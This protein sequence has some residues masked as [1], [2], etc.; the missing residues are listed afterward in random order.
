MNLTTIKIDNCNFP[1][2]YLYDIQNFVWADFDNV[3]INKIPSDIISS[4]VKIG[5]MPV[6]S[7]I[8]GKVKKIKLKPE[9]G[10]I[11]K[12]KS[13]GTLESLNYFGVI[14]SPISGEIVEINKDLISD[15]EKI[16]DSPFEFGW[17]A[18]IKPSDSNIESLQS[19]DQCKSEISHLIKK[20][21][22]KCFK[23][24]PDFEMYELGTECSATLAK[25][26]EFMEKR[27]D[28]GQIVH[29]VSDDPTADLEVTRWISEH[30]QE[31]V[32]ISM[33][34]NKIKFSDAAT[35]YLFH[36]LIKKLI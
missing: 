19:I 23:I 22:V 24:F 8:S 29:L 3:D 33:E 16:N 13:I 25:L 30:N 12:G 17:V 28:I 32:E 35:N 11:I 18:K 27:M 26:D 20:F 36:I 9:G 34:K 6:L 14:R 31:L 7:Y 4:S 1:I 10:T 21:N 15:P 5:V 2:R